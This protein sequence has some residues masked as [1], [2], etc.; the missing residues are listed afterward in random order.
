MAKTKDVKR[1]K[2][3]T[4]EVATIGRDI[5]RWTYGGVIENLDD[6]LRTRGGGKGLKI[7]DELERDAHCY[8]ELQKRKLAVVARP[9]QVDAASDAALDKDAA[10]LVTRQLKALGKVIDDERQLITGFDQTTANFLDATLKGFAVGEVMWEAR[11]AELWASRVIPRDQRR[12][13]FGEDLRLR[14]LTRE[15]LML[16]EELPARKFILHRFGAKDD[17][18]HG[19]GLG[20]ILFWPVFFKRQDIGFWLVFA[21]KFGSPTAVGKYPAGAKADEKR[22]LLQA[23]GAIAQDAGI[24]VPEGMLI[25]L[26]E[27]TRAGTTNTYETLARYMDEQIS[28]AV[29]GG[30]VTTQAQST[31]LGSGVANV[32]DDV[33]IEIATADADLLS[34]TLNATLVRWIV[35]YNLPGATPPLLY[36]N[37]EDDAGD[38]INTFTIGLQRLVAMGLKVPAKW[39]HDKW[40]IP[41]AGEGEEVLHAPVLASPDGAD[42]AL[43]FAEGDPARETADQAALAAA[44]EALSGEWQRVLGPRLEQLLAFA[45]ESGD[46]A[47]L[48]ERLVELAAAPPTPDLVESLERAGFSAQL[49]ARTPVPRAT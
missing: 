6:T 46:Y 49:L 38:E 44:A 43:Q 17:A 5:T 10:D 31:G 4:R 40:N 7:Y 33:R 28:K 45:E 2:P 27:A 34:D 23:L 3:E 25:E 14:M 1:P 18:P 15:N 36:R 11:G 30:T 32:Q 8:A 29:L 20:H 9:W 39:A 21:D 19:K 22:T 26:L 12:F 35:E 47:T 24:I 41:L 13:V 37:F 48:R 42:P 16:G